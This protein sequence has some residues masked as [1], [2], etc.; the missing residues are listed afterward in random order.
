M[1]QDIEVTAVAVIKESELPEEQGKNLIS[2]FSDFLSKAQ[3]LKLV[4]Y[5]ISIQ[6]VSQKE[7]MSKAREMRLE[8]KDIRISADK[9]RKELKEQSLREGRAIDGLGNI[10]KAIIVPIEEYLEKQEKFAE[11]IEKERIE[12][13]NAFR[14]SE[15][16]KYTTTPEMY[17]F[18]EMPDEVFN[19]LLVSVKDA[20][21]KKAEAEAKAEQDRIA[22]FQA[23]AEEQARIKAENDKLKAEADQR[24]KELALEKA[25][26]EKKELEDKAT[27]EVEEKKKEEA[28]K[29]ELARIEEEKKKEREEKE[30]LEKEL[31]DKEAAELKAKQEKEKA[32]RDAQLAPEKDKLFAFAERIKT[33]ETPQELSKA[34]LEIVKQAESKLLLISQEV[35]EA[36]KNL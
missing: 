26:R 24:E 9:L 32:E 30:K 35:K 19:N 33:V 14:L 5:N 29:A 2:K 4:A 13:Q 31:K 12:K 16:Q 11:N 22:K 7:D 23:D 27:R 17:N 15:L 28:H 10:V 20:Y 34:G 6:D 3:Q 21:D 18:K 1:E 25:E 36:I 8:A